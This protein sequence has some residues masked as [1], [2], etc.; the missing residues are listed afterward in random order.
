M[1]ARSIEFITPAN[2]MA[3]IGAY[4]HVAKVG[5]FIAIGAVAGVDPDTGDLAGPTI[6][7]QVSQIIKSL[8]L[9]LRAVG[10]DLDHVVRVNVFLKDMGDFRAMDEAYTKAMNGRKPAHTVV[11]VAD[12]PKP[13]ALAT[14][15][16][17]A[18]AV[19]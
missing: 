3:P 2:V 11:A 9:M 18:I 6:S 7:Q 15:N 17:T 13:G 5:D 14:M 19:R 1:G 4:R 16:L 12:L 8:E 10:S